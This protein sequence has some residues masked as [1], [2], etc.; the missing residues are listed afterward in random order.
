MKFYD[1][2]SPGRILSRVG[3]DIATIDDYLPWVNFINFYLN[4]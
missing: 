4:N 2:N 1:D 3:K